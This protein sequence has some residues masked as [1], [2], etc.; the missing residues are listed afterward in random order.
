MSRGR[1][2]PRKSATEEIAED[3]SQEDENKSTPTV[4]AP[5]PPTKTK[6]SKVRGRPSKSLP[7]AKRSR[8]SSSSTSTTEDNA[9][10]C[11]DLADA[12]L[13]KST[14]VSSIKTENDVAEYNISSTSGKCQNLPKVSSY[15]FVNFFNSEFFPFF[16]VNDIIL[17]SNR[18]IL[19]IT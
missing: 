19:I 9:S 14:D 16:F 2:R 5:P 8:T 4:P 11:S 7:P 15:D 13:T 18:S 6:S 17:Y 3:Q 1:G 10:A 12:K